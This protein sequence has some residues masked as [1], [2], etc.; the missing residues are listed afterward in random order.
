MFGMAHVCRHQLSDELRD[1]W[2]A[3]MCGLCLSLRDAHGQ[4]SRAVTNTDAITLSI[5][6]EAQQPPGADRV[7]AGRCALRGMRTA[8]VVPAEALSAR[9][10]RTASLTLAAAKAQ[11]VVAEQRAGLTERAPV[12]AAAAGAVATRLRRQALADVPMAQTVHAVDLLEQLAGQGEIERS[13]TVGDGLDAV[14]AAAARSAEEVFAASA[15]VAGRPENEAAL[16]RL[17]RAYGALAHLLDAVED[18]DTDR[19]RGDFNPL[20]A[21]GWGPR[22]A[23]ERCHTLVGE[24]REAFGAL[25]LTDDRLV[26]LLVVDGSAAAVRK[27]F[28][29]AGVDRHS[30]GI[31]CGAAGS[32]SLSPGQYPPQDAP[33]GN[34]GLPP[35]YPP[36]PPAAPYGQGQPGQYPGYPPPPPQDQPPPPDGPDQWPTPL[37]GNRPFWRNLMPWVGVY[38][39]GVACCAEHTNPCTG[40]RHAAACGGCDCGGCD[41]CSG[42]GDCCDCC[43]CCDCNC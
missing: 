13:V 31:A 40:R 36:G 24:I 10:G 6:V 18:L 7:P 37:P 34:P 14:T 21:A 3:H 29:A 11:D 38:C 26:R 42:C 12:R 20:L 23:R 5:L 30:H 19:R 32:S 41:G 25:Q 2:L 1:Q 33:R 43:D 8:A 9:L 4:A 17:G 35:V 22:R 39:C 27:A 15:A 16:R 28:G